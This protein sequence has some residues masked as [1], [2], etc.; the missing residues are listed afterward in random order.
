MDTL[1][2]WLT[3]ALGPTL[4]FWLLLGFGVKEGT[5]VLKGVS[6]GAGNLTKQ[7]WLKV[8]GYG[9]LALASV[10]AIGATYGFD[11]NLFSL[12]ES[13]SGTDPD[14]MQLISALVT[15]GMARYFKRQEKKQV[16][17]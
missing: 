8:G 7:Q 11:I 4:I 10:V 14:L 12:F 5:E 9:S 6:R 1:V 3:E 13:F 15:L 17:P 2:T 16:A